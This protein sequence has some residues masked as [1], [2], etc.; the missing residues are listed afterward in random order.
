MATELAY[1]RRDLCPLTLY[2]GVV[3]R[4]KVYSYQ[5]EKFLKA[6]K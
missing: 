1:A 2:G 6:E 4:Y 3:L 5:L